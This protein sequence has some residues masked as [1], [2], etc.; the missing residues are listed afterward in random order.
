MW[1]PNSDG[2]WGPSYH[3]IEQF[4]SYGYY[5]DYGYHYTT[6]NFDQQPYNASNYQENQYANVNNE[7]LVSL[8][9]GLSGL[10]IADGNQSLNEV[11]E[12]VQAS[13]YPEEQYQTS[14]G[15]QD[16]NRSP[17]LNYYNC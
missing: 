10:A 15:H 16:L 3:D 17:S 13:N 6:N 12:H 8:Q 11:P 7:I 2:K 5:G 1:E 4:F 14:T 9:H